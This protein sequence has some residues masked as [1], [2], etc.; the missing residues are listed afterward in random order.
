MSDDAKC[1]GCG[2]IGRRRRRY[3][4][5]VGWYYLEA[6]DDEDPNSTIIVLACSEACMVMQWKPGPGDRF[7][8]EE[9][10]MSS[11]DER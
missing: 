8:D 11:E 1:D 9:L 6:K 10:L 3:P 5:P 4:C 7:T 2:K